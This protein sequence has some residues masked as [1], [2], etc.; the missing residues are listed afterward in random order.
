[1]CHKWIV[2]WTTD[3]YNIY[4]LQAGSDIKNSGHLNEIVTRK[5][6]EGMQVVMQCVEGMQQDVE[7][8]I[9]LG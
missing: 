4:V 8:Y 7:F 2:H 3:N 1:M 6:I 5:I 9:K